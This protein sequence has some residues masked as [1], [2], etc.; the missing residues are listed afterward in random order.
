MDEDLSLPQFC[1]NMKTMTVERFTNVIGMTY[2]EG[3]AVYYFRVLQNAANYLRAL[4]PEA[5][6]RLCAAPVSV[7]KVAGGSVNY[8]E[9]VDDDRR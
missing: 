1:A 2:T 5:L 6:E 9:F 4:P 3:L 8:K 7:E